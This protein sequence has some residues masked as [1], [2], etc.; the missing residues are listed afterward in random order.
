VS[1]AIIAN[2]RQVV[3]AADSSKFGRNA[4]V[5]LGSISLVDCLVT[6]QAPA[7]ALTQLLNQYK[8][9]LEVV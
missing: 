1:Q 5:R 4:M 9:R 2:A 6:D 3:L 7:P 8:I